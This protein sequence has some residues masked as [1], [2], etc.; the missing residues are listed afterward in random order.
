MLNALQCTGIHV[1]RVCYGM[2]VIIKIETEN[3]CIRD[4]HH[5]SDLWHTLL[6]QASSNGVQVTR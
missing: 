5:I 2:L 6:C 3:A 1:V 4:N